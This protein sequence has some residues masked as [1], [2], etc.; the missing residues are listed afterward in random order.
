[1][2]KY[3]QQHQNGEP[4]QTV[5]SIVFDNSKHWKYY[6]T[7]LDNYGTIWNASHKSLAWIYPTR[8][9]QSFGI[10]EYILNIYHSGVTWLSSRRIYLKMRLR[11]KPSFFMNM[12][13]TPLVSNCANKW[14]YINKSTVID[15]PITKYHRVTP[16]LLSTKR[17]AF[18][19]G[20]ARTEKHDKMR[21]KNL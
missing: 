9:I 14:W 15:D 5:V 21:N 13:K 19:T 20:S 11:P 12:L 2:R 8:T 3:T 7:A 16:W 10:D 18:D 1:M 17:H 4:K 6:Q